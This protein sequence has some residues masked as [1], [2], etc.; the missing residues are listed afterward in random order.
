GYAKS[1]NLDNKALIKEN[2]MGIRPAPGYPACPDHTEKVK[3]FD[4][5]EAEKHTGVSLTES[6]AMNPVSSVC[7]WYFSHPESLY[8]GI[9]KIG[10]DQVKKLAKQKSMEVDTLKKWLSPYL[11]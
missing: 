8:F 6:L 5:L 10:N 7:G 4:L 2:Y 1:E 3:L 11:R 9:S